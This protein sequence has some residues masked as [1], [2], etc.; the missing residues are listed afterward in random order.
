VYWNSPTQSWRCRLAPGPWHNSVVLSLSCG[1]RHPRTFR[2]TELRWW[3]CVVRLKDTKCFKLRI[4]SL[5]ASMLSCPL[6]RIGLCRN[7]GCKCSPKFKIKPKFPYRVLDYRHNSNKENSDK[8]SEQ[9]LKRKKCGSGYCSGSARIS[10]DFASSIQVMRAAS[11][12][13]NPSAEIESDFTWST[14][15]IKRWRMPSDFTPRNIF[16]LGG[17]SWCNPL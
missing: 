6:V 4:F 11:V 7:N 13:Q 1:H 8:L 2:N 14:V 3:K 10:S 12:W 17:Y 9:S 16:G 5:C 15:F